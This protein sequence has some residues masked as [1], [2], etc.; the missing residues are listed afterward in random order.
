MG[1]LCVHLR[2]EI[3]P[4]D[5]LVFSLGYLSELS[6]FC[7]SLKCESL[8]RQSAQKVSNSCSSNSWW[9]FKLVRRKINLASKSRKVCQNKALCS[10]VPA[11]FSSA[12]IF[13]SKVEA[14]KYGHRKPGCVFPLC[15]IQTLILN[16]PHSWFVFFK[17]LLFVSVRCCIGN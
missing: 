12:K 6:I 15:L 1:L 8:V 3:H 2:L 11:S 14:R 13:A 17:I 4:R 9:H 10:N 16:M 7:V 5:Q